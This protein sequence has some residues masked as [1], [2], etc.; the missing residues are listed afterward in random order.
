LFTSRADLLAQVALESG[1]LQ[2]DPQNGAI[3]QRSGRRAELLDKRTGYGRV[4]V[5]RTPLVL[6]MAHRVIW[7][8][9]HGLIPNGLQINHINRRRWD[10][11]I[12][13]LELVTPKGNV[14]HARALGYDRVGEGDGAVDLGWL[15]CLDKG[16]MPPDER[17]HSVNDWSTF[18]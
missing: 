17:L 18:N 3:T 16:E 1:E 9:V 5:K 14:R 10:N 12:E 8:S 15:D 7:I 13:N 11:R 4:A 6:A 2:V